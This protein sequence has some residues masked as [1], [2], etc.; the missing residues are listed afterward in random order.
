MKLQDIF[1]NIVPFAPAAKKKA[2]KEAEARKKRKERA[3]AV[4]K[5]AKETG[6][7]IEVNRRRRE[8]Q[9]VD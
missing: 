8:M 4:L 9:S 6:K 3:Q 7:E 5:K 1:E 2:D